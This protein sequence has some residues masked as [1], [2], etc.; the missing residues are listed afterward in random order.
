MRTMEEIARKRLERDAKRIRDADARKR[1]RDARRASK[2]PD[3]KRFIA[4]AIRA[5]MEHKHKSE[6]A[7][8]NRFCDSCDALVLRGRAVFIAASNTF[9]CASCARGE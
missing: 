7:S 1:A 9:S 3:Q 5:E 8:R 2:S 4:R 6:C